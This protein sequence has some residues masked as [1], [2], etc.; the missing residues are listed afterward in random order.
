MESV[1]ILGYIISIAFIIGAIVFAG[2]IVGSVIPGIFLVYWGI[3]LNSGFGSV[4]LLL[5]IIYWLWLV[6]FFFIIHKET[7]GL[8]RS[9]TPVRIMR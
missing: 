9:G 5:G 3:Q 7:I 2:L 4:I 8:D 6:V 1:Y